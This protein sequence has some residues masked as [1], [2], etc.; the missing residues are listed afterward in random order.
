M[1]LIYLDLQ[2]KNL[3]ENRTETQ[4][5]F[6]DNRDTIIVNNAADYDLSVIR[7]QTDTTLL[8]VFTAKIEN[9]SL[10]VNDTIYYVT[11][12]RGA[13]ITTRRVIWEPED[14]TAPI[15]Q[16]PSLLPNGEQ[17][18]RTNYYNCF[19]YQHF[20]KLINKAL[21]NAF[22]ALIALDPTILVPPPY[23][24]WNTNSLTAELV[25]D[26]LF[27]TDFSGGVDLY[28]N[29]ALYDLFSS[30]SADKV[31]LS[32]NRDYRLMVSSNNGYNL[33]GSYIYLKQ[34]YSTISNWSPV[35]SIVFASSNLATVPGL[36]GNP[37]IL[38]DGQIVPASG[39]SNNT[40]NLISD[41]SANEQSFK[42]N[43]LYNPSAQYRFISLYSSTPITNVGIQ[44][45]W[46]S[47]AGEFFPLLFSSQGSA[48]IKLL[49]QKK[50]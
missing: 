19:N 16:A 47:T 15:P 3:S 27:D 18:S 6:Q 22:L 48:S 1:D 39:S 5:E 7:F 43:I 9:N 11:L 20:I 38:K 29:S 41:I 30:F 25:C 40:I 10:N 24:G 28:F 17:V 13:F 50:K 2:A 31:F 12:Q 36:V 46:K 49:F 4:I 14:L 45:F 23:L 34:N 26:T 33:V 35:S 8:P 42:P 44:V 37:F 32:Q 21:L